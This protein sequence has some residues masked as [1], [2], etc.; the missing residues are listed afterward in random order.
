[1]SGASSDRTASGS[2]APLQLWPTV[3]LAA[4]KN[5]HGSVVWA[6]LRLGHGRVN[7]VIS[8]SVKSGRGSLN[9]LQLGEAEEEAF[10]AMALLEDDGDLEVAARGLAAHDDALSEGGVAHLVACGNARDDRT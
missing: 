9:L 1:M 7:L 10:D 2:T 5:C 6:S 8:S 3:E 4:A